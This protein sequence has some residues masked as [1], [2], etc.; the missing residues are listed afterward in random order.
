MFLP[1][2][3]STE[4]RA[5]FDMGGI[6]GDVMFKHVSTSN[7]SIMVNLSGLVTSY[8]WQIHTFPAVYHGNVDHTCQ[9]M[10]IGGIFDPLNKTSSRTTDCKNSNACAVGDLTGKH[11]NLK[12]TTENMFDNNLPLSGPNSIFGRSLVLFDEK[13]K[14]VACALVDASNDVIT[15]VATFRGETSGVTGTVTLRQSRCN[16]SLGTT[17]DV[18][19][20]YS[21][22][23][24]SGS[25]NF[26]LTISDS[27]LPD[28]GI[29]SYDG[30]TCLT[31][32]ARRR[33]I[34]KTVRIPLAGNGSSTERFL[35]NV[36]NISL[37]G[38][39]SAIGK[40]LILFEKDSPKICASIYE[41]LPIEAEG[42][43]DVDGVKGMIHFK[44]NSVFS[45]TVVTADVRGLKSEA[46]K[47]HVHV[48]EVLDSAMLT[49]KNTRTMCGSKHTAG[50][51]NP[52][53][54]KSA[55]PGNGMFKEVFVLELKGVK[56]K[57]SIGVKKNRGKRF[58]TIKQ[59]V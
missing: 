48:N 50:H 15:A 38:A 39:Q 5:V 3:G 40:T 24:T 25:K 14:P 17:V 47:Y 13:S 31:G 46:K 22:D 32:S 54:T 44:Q 10:H 36:R 21:N 34:S 30:K 42:V 43:F 28:E 55:K 4:L 27:N 19:L 59:R 41:V 7:T 1:G 18:N 52:Y 11:G 23:M 2:S 35:L 45:P 9:A 49:H 8:A 33:E 53:G 56:R 20:F 26:T 29:P 6:K 12:T 51:W 16:P 57:C 58:L 37:F